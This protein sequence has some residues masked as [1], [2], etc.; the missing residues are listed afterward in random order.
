MQEC[1]HANTPSVQQYRT[2]II[3]SRTI[4]NRWP[5]GD[6]ASPYGPTHVLSSLVV[7]SLA[8]VHQHCHRSNNTDVQVRERRDGQQPAGSRKSRVISKTKTAAVAWELRGWPA[9]DRTWAR[10]SHTGVAS[11]LGNG[12][13]WIVKL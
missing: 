7:S 1:M 2:S 3:I 13:A 6:R 5:L 9:T 12:G 11:C 4:L 8:T 10:R